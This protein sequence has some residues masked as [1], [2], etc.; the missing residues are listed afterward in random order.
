MPAENVYRLTGY[1]YGGE[2]TIGTISKSVAAYWLKK[3]DKVFEKYMTSPQQELF[4]KN[5]TIPE[6]F[7]LPKW[8]ELDDLMHLNSLEFDPLNWL[9]IENNT[10]GK[11]V[12]EI[13]M[14][15]RLVGE[16]HN[17]IVEQTD[18]KARVLV[19]GQSFEKGYF[20][21]GNLTTDEPF[22]PSNLKI[23]ITHWNN[24]KVIDSIAYND[25]SLC[26]ETGETEGKGLRCWIAR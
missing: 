26:A 2:Y 21:F 17:P 23:N 5:L 7:Q 24:I 15:E 3:G 25:E 8:Y 12:T 18:L 13:F 19:Y 20:D 6:E 16:M 1:R 22:E 9:L 14:N 4:N 10:T 11:N